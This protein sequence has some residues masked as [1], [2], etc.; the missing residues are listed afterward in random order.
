[1]PLQVNSCTAVPLA[2]PAPAT[3]T[4]LPARPVI[5]PAPPVGGG[6]APPDWV[7]DQVNV[8]DVRDGRV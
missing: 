3:S 4:H 5:W 2:V 7:P 8:A 1:V 6:V